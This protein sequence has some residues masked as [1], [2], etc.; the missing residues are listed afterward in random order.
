MIF[1][2]LAGFSEVV[3]GTADAAVSAERAAANK[4]KALWTWV[5]R[6]RSEGIGMP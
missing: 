2:H 3:K 6:Q 5:V 4:H 1:R